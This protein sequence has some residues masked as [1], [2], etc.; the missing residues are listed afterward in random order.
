MDPLPDVAYRPTPT[1][2]AR[3]L[4]ART[5]DSHG[6]EQGDWGDD[7]RPSAADVDA[8]IDQ[9]MGPVLAFVGPLDDELQ[10]P[11]RPAAFHLVV[12]GTACLVEKSYFPEQV[13]SNR[14][15]YPEYKTEYD[16]LLGRLVGGGDS[17]GDGG[18]MPGAGGGYGTLRTPS[19]YVVDA[20][21]WWWDHWPEPENPANWAQPFQPPREPPEPE[22]LPVGDEPASP[23]TAAERSDVVWPPAPPSI[24]LP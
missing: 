7:T 12:L 2:V 24:G 3:L 21:G 17:G 6:V 10:A 19:A 16:N 18:V 9:A 13:Q 5:Q 15:A 1:D 22:D 8:L 23:V 11:L 20:Y 14:S 4:R